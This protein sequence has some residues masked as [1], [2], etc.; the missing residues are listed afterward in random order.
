MHVMACTTPID[1]AVAH[2]RFGG[3]IEG[4]QPMQLDGIAAPGTAALPCDTCH[5]ISCRMGS[6]LTA[7]MELGPHHP[8]DR[9]SVPRGHML[10]QPHD[11]ARDLWIVTSGLAVIQYVLPDGRRQILDFRFPGEILCPGLIGQHSELSAQT[12]CP[13]E[14]CH[15]NG[16]DLA[17]CGAKRPALLEEL[18][19]IAC[20]QIKRANLQML[21]LGR[22]S[23]PERIAT[24][25][26]QMA[27]R[28]GRA[29]R[30]GMEID[31]PMNRD[32]IADYLGLNPETVS[33]SL[34]R[35]KKAGTLE[36]PQPGRAV[37]KDIAALVAMTPYT[38]RPEAASGDGP[39]HRS[40]AQPR[41][42]G[43]PINGHGTH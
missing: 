1:F 29:R 11:G 22:L 10:M 42:R 6:H 2:G 28:A 19:D 15:I 3:A 31:L 9:V 32:D 40:M 20:A 4:E 39:I 25:L 7:L 17:E 27:D 8:L 35:L 13:T 23:V 43:C 41:E 33:R 12:V 38:D 14:L 37:L 16:R 34:T 5:V 36:L 30:D 24:F 26:L 21:L 18:F